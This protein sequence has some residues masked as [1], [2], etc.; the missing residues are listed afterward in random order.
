MDRARRKRSSVG[1]LM[2]LAAIDMLTAALVCAVVLF[3]VLVGSESN[4]AAATPGR[5]IV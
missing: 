5:R 1:P 3:L 2:I 4:E